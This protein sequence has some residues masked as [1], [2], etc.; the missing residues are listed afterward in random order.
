MLDSEQPVAFQ[1]LRGGNQP[2]NVSAGNAENVHANGRNE[3]ATTARRACLKRLPDARHIVYD[4]EIRYRFRFCV[5][6]KSA[7]G[8]FV[9]S[10]LCPILRR[11]QS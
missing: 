7:L 4:G 1:R 11:C 9:R 2:E 8:M 10:K 5:A 6:L 3:G